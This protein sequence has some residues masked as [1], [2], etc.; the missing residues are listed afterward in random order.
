MLL[1]LDLQSETDFRDFCLSL[2]HMSWSKDVQVT[3]W[4]PWEFRPQTKLLQNSNLVIIRLLAHHTRSHWYLTGYVILINDL[5][6]CLRGLKLGV[7]KVELQAQR[8]THL[9]LM[10]SRLSREV[11]QHG[12]KSCSARWPD[13]NCKSVWDQQIMLTRTME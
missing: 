9:Y 10:R 8:A 1:Y 4:Y 6:S 12:H 13:E 7:A 3:P 11:L 2:G 5:P